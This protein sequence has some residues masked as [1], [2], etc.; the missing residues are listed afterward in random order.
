MGQNRKGSQRAYSVRITQEQTS[1]LSSV[2]S[3]LCQLRPNAPLF[4]GGRSNQVPASDPKRF[5]T[6]QVR[7]RAFASRYFHFLPFRP[8]KASE[9]FGK[10]VNLAK[11]ADAERQEVREAKAFLARQ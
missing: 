6:H 3:D 2:T 5:P 9:Y 7:G 8:P 10:L 4:D 1:S 11:N